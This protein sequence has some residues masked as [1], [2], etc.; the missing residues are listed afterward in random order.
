ML[1]DF[2][3]IVGYMMVALSSII[4]IRMVTSGV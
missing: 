3:E 2:A 1:C 4:A